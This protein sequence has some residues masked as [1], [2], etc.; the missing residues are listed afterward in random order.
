[1]ILV[2]PTTGGGTFPETSAENELVESDVAGSI[3]LSRQTPRGCERPTV[4][5]H[6]N[7]GF[8]QFFDSPHLKDKS[9]FSPLFISIHFTQ[10]VAPWN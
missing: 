9:S 1:M 4:E 8:L 5:Q 7:A 10:S 6:N 3:H 2:V